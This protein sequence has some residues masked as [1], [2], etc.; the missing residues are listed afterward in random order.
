MDWNALP[1][2]SAARGK[3]L[4][5]LQARKHRAREGLFVAEGVRLVEEAAGCDA[6]IEWAVAAETDEPRCTA[7]VERLARQ[8]EV[9]RAGDRELSR[10]LDTASPQGV[11]ALCRIPD[12]KLESLV[13]P[14]R[15]LIVICDTLRDP[16]NLGA[17]VRT[18]AAAGCAAVVVAGQSVDPW[19]PKAVR[20]SMGAVFRLPVIV[21]DSPA[22]CAG[23]LEDNHFTTYLAD[24]GG[25]DLFTLQK[26][27]DRCALIIG[28]EAGGAG[29]FSARLHSAAVSIPLAPG[30][31]SLNA[32]VAAGIIIYHLRQAQHGAGR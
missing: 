1:D 16:G 25:T 17:V 18:A 6:G 7:L 30:A 13:L 12:H 23:Y 24:M 8:T 11:A 28:G 29:A 21:S 26:V 31:E 15:A 20:G 5:K 9:C 14:A 4:R 2:L 32:A 10:L 22:R 19:N 27:P 3:L